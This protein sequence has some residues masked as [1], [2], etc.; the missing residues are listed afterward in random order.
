MLVAATGTGGLPV[1]AE[2]LRELGDPWFVYSEDFGEDLFFAARLEEAGIP[3]LLDTGC[4]MGHI[5]PAAVFPVP[6]DSGWRL[7]FVYS[8]GTKIPM[9][10]NHEKGD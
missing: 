2:V 7:E 3:M 5:A 10:M 6:I 4:R 8:D 9:D 1:R